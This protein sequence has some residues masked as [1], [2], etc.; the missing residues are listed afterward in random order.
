MSTK[1][2]FLSTCLV[3]LFSLPFN[4]VYAQLEFTTNV[5]TDSLFRRTVVYVIDLDGDEDIDIISANTNDDKISW[6][7]NNG[8]Q[9][10]TEHIIDDDFFR[11]SEVIAVDLDQDG[12][13]DV[14]ATGES[15]SV[16]F[17]QNNGHQQ[18]TELAINSHFN[19][20]GHLFAV[21]LDD[22]GDIDVIGAGNGGT[23]WWEN[24]GDNEFESHFIYQGTG[25][26][27]Y[28]ADMDGDN[29]IDILVGGGR[30]RWLSN[31]GDQNFDLNNVSDG[32]Y[33]FA[34]TTYPVDLDEDGDLDVIGCSSFEEDISWFENDGTEDFTAHTIDNDLEYPNSVLSCDLDN[35]GDI[36]V[37]GA[38]YFADEISWYEN[39]GEEQFEKYLISNEIETMEIT[40]IDLDL[41]G[42]I[43]IIASSYQGEIIW[44]ENHLLEPNLR[45]P[46][47]FS[48]ISPENDSII[49]HFP[50]WLTW[51]N[52]VDPDE[53]D[54]VTFTV[55][56]STDQF[57]TEFRMMEGINAVTDTSVDI[58]D[59]INGERYW[60]KVL[61]EDIAGNQTWSNEIWSFAFDWEEEDELFTAYTSSPE[62][63]SEF[64]IV[65]TYPNPFNPILN[66]TV[67]I[68]E[69][70]EISVTVT[71][72]YGQ[73][74]ATLL[75]GPVSTG[76]KNVVFNA[77][78]LSSVIYFIQALVPGKMNEIK[79]VVLMK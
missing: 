35:D 72:I 5:V 56:F 68:P 32:A 11:P 74:V 58:I 76:Y 22:D 4:S 13:I 47:P 67:G 55:F 23:Y 69:T 39:D 49:T 52:T 44:F 70:S 71:N 3:V 73:H 75:N 15:D 17:W 36:D 6:F 24:E 38:D 8:S 77:S 50:L 42:D 12:D 28:A 63:P 21:D 14:I 60:W 31:D 51:Q 34:S 33:S 19:N 61:A 7:E 54:S 30:I 66:I 78:H 79:K 10:F 26:D 43:D 25:P 59:L 20:G 2:V 46:E 29:D 37:I 57:F 27:I 62:I 64:S 41:D 40:N 16:A 48:L 1:T 45:P 18:F 65:S 53:G 9:E